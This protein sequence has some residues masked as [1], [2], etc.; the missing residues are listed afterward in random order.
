MY[1]RIH[2][3]KG[4]FISGY[5][6]VGVYV[7]LAE[8]QRELL[9]CEIRVDQGERN[10]VKRQVPSRIP[11]VFPL[12]RHGDYVSVVQVSPLMIA[13]FPSLPGWGRVVWIASQPVSDDVVI[14]L[15]G[16]EHSRK[17]LPHD[18][19]RVCGEILRNDRC[20]KFIGLTPPQ[21]ELFIEG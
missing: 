8:H 10:A 6:P 14:E 15:L 18:V 13:P 12:V 3:A 4:P 1:G 5:L 2:V 7:P 20:V 11:W 17:T 19:L 9:F 21:R 16:P